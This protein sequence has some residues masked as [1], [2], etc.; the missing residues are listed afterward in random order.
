MEPPGSARHRWENRQVEM[1]GEHMSQR[2]QQ[3]SFKSLLIL[4]KSGDIYRSVC[5]ILIRMTY[6]ARAKLLRSASHSE[7]SDWG[8][9]HGR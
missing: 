4:I 1:G 9:R 2:G 6:Q 7:W 5:F 3:T 8:E